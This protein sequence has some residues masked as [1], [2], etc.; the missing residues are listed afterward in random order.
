MTSVRISYEGDEPHGSVV[1]AAE[2]INTK[3][4]AVAQLP[5]LAGVG[6]PVHL[7][8]HGSHLVR[9]WL[10]SGQ[11]LRATFDAGTD[12][13]VIVRAPVAA[14]APDTDEPP[15]LA[16][17]MQAWALI[18]AR[19]AGQ[20]QPV[21]TI[22][23]E[24]GQYEVQLTIPATPSGSAIVQVGGTLSTRMTVV[25][26]P[27]VAQVSIQQDRQFG[28]ANW[29]WRVHLPADSG[30]MLLSYLANGNLRAARILAD[31]FLDMSA[32]SNAT[33]LLAAAAGYALLRTGDHDKLCTLIR[34]FR[35]DLYEL[36]DGAVIRAWRQLHEPQPAVPDVRD[37]LQRAAAE[38]PIASEG[39]RLLYRGLSLLA[40]RRPDD[41]TRAALVRIRP[42][43]AAIALQPDP[44]TT[45][46]GRA[47]DEL[48]IPPIFTT[49]GEARQG[50]EPA[51]EFFLL[52]ILRSDTRPLMRWTQD[53]TS[54]TTEKPAAMHWPREATPEPDSSPSAKAVAEMPDPDPQHTLTPLQRNILKVIQESLQS[55][56]Y[57]PL[58]RE[59]AK[60]IGMTSTGSVTYQLEILALKGFVRWDSG[61]P[62]TLEVLSPGQPAFHPGTEAD[63]V[64]PL[65]IPSQPAAYVPLASGIANG[66]PIPSNKGFPMPKQVVGE[67]KLFLFKAVGDSMIDAAIADGDWIVV[68]QQPLAENGEIVAATIGGKATLKTLKRSN[69]HVWL[70]PQ[71]TAYEPI[72][73]DD[74][75]ILGRAVAV[76]RAV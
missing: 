43:A 51:R 46:N 34:R 54:L 6:Q 74:A 58:R 11:Q 20:W 27:G 57:P 9:G 44:M 7:D 24:L 69:G 66:H 60:A 1:A 18:W 72:P 42:V 12:E 33:P 59:I 17:I 56:G 40:R 30:V 63:D 26:A 75:T 49:P 53:D 19:Q 41:A 39:L 4:E 50:E 61:R 48:S 36:P 38:L 71:N 28:T 22:A 45:F 52:N 31:A 67:G 37:L 14:A 21:P 8:D 76:M 73:G 47:P 3:L 15:S 70:M 32:W 29:Q 5:I 25:P 10:P 35:H 64:S 65:D 62:R 16:G 55:R 23:K 68:R 2:I 13:T